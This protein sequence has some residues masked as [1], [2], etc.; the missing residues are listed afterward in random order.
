MAPLGRS[1]TKKIYMCIDFKLRLF[2]FLFF[3]NAMWMLSYDYKTLDSYNT[4]SQDCD[5]TQDIFEI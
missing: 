2:K 4:I 5:K 1:A 3:N